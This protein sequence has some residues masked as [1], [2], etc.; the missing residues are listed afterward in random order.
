MMTI[1]TCWPMAKTRYRCSPDAV[2]QIAQRVGEHVE[3]ILP[4]SPDGREA[5]ARLRISVV[6][7]WRAP[8]APAGRR[9]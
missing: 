1:S 2:R 8:R 6:T 9:L 7:A 4:H 3:V 5:D